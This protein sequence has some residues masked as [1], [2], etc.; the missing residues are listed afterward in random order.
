MQH[1]NESFSPLYQA[2]IDNNKIA[3]E[4]FLQNGGS[5][6]IIQG[7]LTVLAMAVADGKYEWFSFAKEH[8]ANSNFSVNGETLLSI[9]INEY[10]D[11]GRYTGNYAAMKKQEYINIARELVHENPKSVLELDTNG[12]TYL[13]NAHTAHDLSL[14]NALVSEL[15]H[16]EH[17]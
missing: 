12:H 2:Y 17:Y 14:Y 16:I 13:D 11:V 7:G 3:A 10:I 15:N 6:D 5:I 9:C 8:G 4:T 1:L